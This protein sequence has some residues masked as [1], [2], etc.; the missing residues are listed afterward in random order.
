MRLSDQQLISYQDDGYFLASQLFPPADVSLI[1][2]EIARLCD[3]P[4]DSH[5]REAGGPALRALHG[6]DQ[7]SELMRNLVRDARLL[8]PVEQMLGERVYLHQF[9]VSMKVAYEGDVWKWHQDFA[10]WHH[11]DGL[12]ESKAVTA[13]VFLDPVN[14][15]NA[16]I[17]LIPGTREEPLRPCRAFSRER[18]L[19]TN[20]PEWHE[21]VIADFKY[22]MADEEVTRL[23]EQKGIVAPKGQQGTVLFFHSSVPHGSTWNISPWERV[24]I[25][26]SYNAVTNRPAAGR[27][28]RAEQR[29]GFLAAS[30]AEPLAPVRDL[31]E[32]L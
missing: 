30:S 1:K 22:T 17:Y 32:N 3:L 26:I 15:F 20:A 24:A 29:P 23:A 25:L 5:L 13:A 7:R 14:E 21:N 31:R 18:Q 12:P 4:D 28:R 10:F 6:C 16:P 9:K 27:S 2:R 19:P 8:E 11:N